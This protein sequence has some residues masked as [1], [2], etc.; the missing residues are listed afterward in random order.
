V[1]AP[2]RD[3]QQLV[4]GQ[5]VASGAGQ[6]L[7]F[8]RATA[9]QVGA[10]VDTVLRDPAYPSAAR[11]VRD[12]FRAAGGTGAAADHLV[13]LAVGRSIKQPVLAR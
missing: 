12:S 3:D 4:A 5:V 10:A 9:A 1:V 11:A 6:R 2:I 8:A 13:Q 7:R